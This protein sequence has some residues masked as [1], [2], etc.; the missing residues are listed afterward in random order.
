MDEDYI[1]TNTNI[2]TNTCNIND[3]MQVN[4]LWLILGFVTYGVFIKYFSKDYIF[5]DYDSDDEYN[6]VL[7][8]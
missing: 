2:N 3:N 4:W 1:N 7:C 5:C 8:I 6:G